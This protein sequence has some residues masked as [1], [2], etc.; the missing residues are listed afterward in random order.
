MEKGVDEELIRALV[1][2]P[3]PAPAAGAFAVGAKVECRYKGK[4]R[5]YPGIIADYEDGV[6]AIDYDDGEKESGVSEELIRAVEEAPAPAPAAPSGKY[7]VGAKVEARYRGKKKWYA[8]EVTKVDGD[9]Y[10]ITYEDGDVEDNVAEELIRAVEEAAPA[11]AP[12]AAAEEAEGKYAVGSKVE[13]RYKGKKRYYPGR[14]AS[15]N[16]GEYAID[17]DDGEKESGVAEELIRVVEEAP[18]PAPA[19]SGGFEAGTQVLAR[20]KGKKKWYPGTVMKRNDDGTY[21]IMYDDGDKESGVSADFVK[22]AE[23]VAS[24]EAAPAPAPAARA[25]KVF[26]KG[27]K[28]EAL[29]KGKKNWYAGV[30]DRY[31]AESET[32]DVTYDDGEVEKG[33]KQENI[34]RAPGDSELEVG[35]RI[36]AKYKGKKKYYPGKIARRGDN[37]TYDI[38][39]DDGE[40]E[41]GVARNLIREA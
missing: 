26:E 38:A 8:G 19:A 33:V 5:Y 9:T 21:E 39:Y 13:C 15:Y 24:D 35:A 6:Y 25:A 22:A 20:Y 11:P 4:K 10:S 16:S 41:S 32:Y 27:T 31:D 40:E 36:E 34:A 14:V 3:A 12:A 1:T 2:A 37:G 30:V 7:A 23:V 28:I 17:Y 18:A 29:Y